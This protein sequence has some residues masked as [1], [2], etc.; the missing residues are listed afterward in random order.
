MVPN[1]QRVLVRNVSLFV[2]TKQCQSKQSIYN[3]E[4]THKIWLESLFANEKRTSLG[5][6]RK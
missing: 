2:Y 5:K 6:C 3:F 1:I 4:N